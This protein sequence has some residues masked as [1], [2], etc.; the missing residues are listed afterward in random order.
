MTWD[1]EHLKKRYRTDIYTENGSDYDG[2]RVWGNLAD[3]FEFITQRAAVEAKRLVS[4]KG[5]AVLSLYDD[6]DGKKGGLIRLEF[7]NS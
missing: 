2:M 7:T 3:A 1:T 5:R 4:M 6:L